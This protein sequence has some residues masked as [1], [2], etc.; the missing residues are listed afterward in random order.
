MRACV[1]AWYLMLRCVQAVA[2]RVGHHHC[3]VQVF[4]FASGDR[5]HRNV[6]AA[7][8]CGNMPNE[9]AAKR[10]NLPFKFRVSVA[11]NT[12]RFRKFVRR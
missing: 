8:C 10:I 7:C 3:R 12:S 1:R 4:L 9:S 2:S 6:L 11:T 5:H